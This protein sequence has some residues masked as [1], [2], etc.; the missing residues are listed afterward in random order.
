M[1]TDGADNVVTLEQRLEDIAG[2]YGKDYAK[3]AQADYPFPVALCFKQR[4]GVDL[5]GN[6]SIVVAGCA[7]NRDKH[8]F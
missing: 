7:V 1:R 4:L 6:R 2:R 3:L 5:A 8:G